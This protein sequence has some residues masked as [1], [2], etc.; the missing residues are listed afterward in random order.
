[1][2]EKKCLLTTRVSGGKPAS[3]SGCF[4]SSSPA[5]G[6][7]L[8]PW[9]T[10]QLD[11]T[12]NAYTP[13][14]SFRNR[15][16]RNWATIWPGRGRYPVY[17]DRDGIIS[18]P[19]HGLSLEIWFRDQERVY[20][21]GDAAG[22]EQYYGPDWHGLANLYQTKGGICRYDI[23]PHPGSHNDF[24]GLELEL[25]AL[26]L[27]RLE[28][29]W[30]LLIFRPYDHNG[31]ARV[32]RLVY[33]DQDVLA[34]NRP[35]LRLEKAPQHSYFTTISRGDVASYFQ[36]GEGNSHIDAPEGDCTGLIGYSGLPGELEKIRLALSPGPGKPPLVKARRDIWVIKEWR[37][38]CRFYWESVIS[39]RVEMIQ[40]GGVWDDILR[41]NCGH[42]ENYS[43]DFREG[44]DVYLIFALNRYGFAERSRRLLEKALHHAKWNSFLPGQSPASA[45]LLVAIGDYISISGDLDTA[46][47]W[48]SVLKKIG[49]WLGNRRPLALEPFANRSRI[50]LEA[51]LWRCA[52]FKAL[53]SL[54][55]QIERTGDVQVFTDEYLRLRGEI[56]Q[57]WREITQCPAWSAREALLF[58]LGSYPLQIWEADHP[59]LLE[60]LTR[61]GQNY[62]YH[63]GVFMPF[64][65]EGID[66]ELTARLGQV[67]VRTG[68]EY[69][70][71]RRVLWHTAG[72]AW[73]WPDR[74]HPVTKLGIGDTGHSLRVL[75]QVLLFL[76][77]MLVLEEEDTLEILPGI[78]TSV[79]WSRPNL[80][81]KNLPT[82]YGPLSLS[83]RT[84]GGVTQIDLRPYFHSFRS[85][86]AKLRLRF[87]ATFRLLY[88]DA[89]VH[90]HENALETA[91]ECRKLRICCN[92]INVS[93]CLDN[94]FSGTI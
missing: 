53:A 66:L 52:A 31:L 45:E 4:P 89:P 35:V 93:T 46:G 47:A 57:L 8:P 26:A 23:F 81:I 20:T 90:R 68:K 7:V 9:L 6:W 55:V 54:G 87:P 94:T 40:T 65:F 64:E 56:L 59:A 32:K 13:E 75:V 19:G 10:A 71:Q 76:R 80:E 14:F 12:N 28:P 3:K 43:R 69:D 70:C 72:P 11:P 33:A 34:N 5:R 85:A 2:L 60:A 27:D 51:A 48:W 62:L 37:Q 88:A 29:V 16:C 63:G 22:I 49:Y 86:P 78:F 1:M 24:I 83:C 15:T 18:L 38:D 30:L 92:P 50:R 42:L 82:R 41:M 25:R 44:I 39:P 21:P 79:F 84:L 36:T 91:P 74:V 58:L 61:I 67:L 73:N 77:A 17:V